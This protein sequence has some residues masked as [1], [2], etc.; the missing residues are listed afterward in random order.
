MFDSRGMEDNL[1]LSK[2][3]SQVVKNALKWSKFRDMIYLPKTNEYLIYD[4]FDKNL[5]KKCDRCKHKNQV[6]NGFNYP[7]SLHKVRAYS[8]KNPN[9]PENQKEENYPK[10]GRPQFFLYD[11]LKGSMYGNILK[12]HPRRQDIFYAIK[13]DGEMAVYHSKTKKKLRVNESKRIQGARFRRMDFT[14]IKGKEFLVVAGFNANIL[15]FDSSLNFKYR[16]RVKLGNWQENIDGLSTFYNPQTNETH[17][18]LS[19]TNYHKRDK[20]YLFKIIRKNNGKFKMKKISELDVK[21]QTGWVNYN[22][23]ANAIC[24]HRPEAA[25]QEPIFS[26]IEWGQ[27]NGV[28]SY[29]Y[30]HQEGS[31]VSLHEP[32]N[33]K[34]HGCSGG[35]KR[36]GNVIWACAGDGT[37][38][39]MIVDYK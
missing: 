10:S 3:K 37:L 2:I 39:R 14:K 36:F 26:I 4:S 30:D 21:A 8:V 17:L 28:R 27:E 13:S 9:F 38:R 18:F 22:R 6:P 19:S 24:F 5:K 31:L 25:N 23:T 7:G 1:Y 35:I 33:F 11:Q 29:R 16:N 34:R 15:I 32:I 20:N 12:I